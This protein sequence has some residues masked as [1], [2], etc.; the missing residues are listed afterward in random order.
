MLTS[1]YFV[2]DG[3]LALA[4]PVR[5]GQKMDIRYIN[6]EQ[7]FLWESYT[8]KKSRWFNARF[9]LPTLTIVETTDTKTAVKLRQILTVL[10]GLRPALLGPHHGIKITTY[11]DFPREW[12][13]GTSSTLIWL[14][15]QWAGT[16]PYALLFQTMGG[17]GYDVACAG[18]NGPILYQLKES[19][20]PIVESIDFTPPFIEKLYFV[21][22]GRKQDSRRGIQHYRSVVRNVE[23]VKERLTDLTRSL[24]EVNSLSL[25]IQTMEEHERIVGAALQ[26]P[27]VKDNY[28]DDF[29][30][31]VKSLGA[32]GGDFVLV[33]SDMPEKEVKSYFNEKGLNVFFRY[34][35]M[36]ISSQD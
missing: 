27:L 9:A 13:L 1:E 8:H 3:A 30:G 35:E 11:L 28:F 6:N 20:R 23:Q 5:F 19:V 7:T 18:A 29:P 25:F 17:S 15:A 21:Y 26:L 34:K 32:W 12:G 33:A 10:L 14:L 36:V 16:D 22:L 31:A 2:L 4:L 24:L